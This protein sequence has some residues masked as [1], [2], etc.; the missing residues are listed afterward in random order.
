MW[1]EGDCETCVGRYAVINFAD[2]ET[3]TKNLELLKQKQVRGVDLH[4]DFVGSQSIVTF[5]TPAL[6]PSSDPLKLYVTGFGREVT[7]NQLKEMFPT[8]DDVTL[9]LNPKDGN[10]PIG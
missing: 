3:A 6:T 1:Q 4:V 9:P 5:V 10:R 7:I 8:C 2:E